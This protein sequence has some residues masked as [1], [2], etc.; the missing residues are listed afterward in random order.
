MIQG[1]RGQGQASAAGTKQGATAKEQGARRKPVC[2]CSGG[3]GRTRLQPA[4]RLAAASEE[5][6]Q[7]VGKS[8]GHSGQYVSIDM[9]WAII[10]NHMAVG[11]AAGSEE[12][13]EQE[14]RGW[15]RGGLDGAS[16]GCSP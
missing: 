3:R 9:V 8:W 10:G 6:W 14:E 5:S 16:L 13:P 7:N 15:G 12:P 11:R 4:A 2:C 1:F